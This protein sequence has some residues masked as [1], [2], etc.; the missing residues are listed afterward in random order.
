MTLD[1]DV[2]IDPPNRGTL[3]RLLSVLERED[4]YVSRETANEAHKSR[5]MFNAI[6]NRSQYKLD[7]IFRKDSPYDRERFA[8]RR[9]EVFAGGSLWVTSPEDVI[10]GKLWWADQMGGSDRQAR[11]VAGVLA[12][13]GAALDDAYLD[14]W[15]A[16]L[17]VAEALAE[18][19]AVAGPVTPD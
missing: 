17:G 19:R 9:A 18:C 2:V 8:R 6:S 7:L 11:D 3:A 14:R 5:R 1:A 13:Q 12:V 15:A 4:F 16:E 10:L